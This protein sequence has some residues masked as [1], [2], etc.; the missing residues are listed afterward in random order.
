MNDDLKIYYD[1]M[2]KPWGQLFY[3]IVWKQ[4]DKI[5]ST[6]ILDYGSGFGITANHFAEENHVT[7]IEPNARMVKMRVCEHLYNQIIGSTEQL[8]QLPDNFFDFVLCHN[9]LEYIKNQEEVFKELCRVVKPNGKISIVKYN[10]FG[11]IMQKVVFENNIYEAVS[12]F[13]GNSLEV[14]NFGHDNYYTI[15]DITQW[16]NNTDVSIEKKYGVGTFFVLQQNNK[17]KYDKTWMEKMFMVEM[18]ASDI[19]EYK[20]IAFFNHIV[21]TKEYA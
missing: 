12:L 8:K 11:R 10:H 6:K 13:D 3:K 18:K 19:D 9:V 2:N 14:L 1:N 7:A 20:N 21:L 17:I 4:L 15:D 5:N 16:L